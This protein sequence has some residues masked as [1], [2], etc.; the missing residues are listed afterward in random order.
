VT[1]QVSNPYK[2]NCKITVLYTLIFILEDNKCEN[3][4]VWT[5]WQQAFPKFNFLLILWII[6]ENKSPFEKRS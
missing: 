2:T 1:D 6:A 3:K 4:R 5:E